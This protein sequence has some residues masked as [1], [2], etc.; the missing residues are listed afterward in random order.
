MVSEPARGWQD[1]QELE[2]DRAG[3]GGIQLQQIQSQS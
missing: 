3:G 2:E 1:C